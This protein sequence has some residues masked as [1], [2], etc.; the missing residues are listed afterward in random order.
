MNTTKF[1]KIINEHRIK[2]KMSK[3]GLA[4]KA[5]VTYRAFVYWERGKRSI[6]L[7]NAINL[8]HAVGLELDFKNRGDNDDINRTE[9]T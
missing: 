4:R 6:G 3:S 9:N 7:E 8:L 2:K 5:G 1:M